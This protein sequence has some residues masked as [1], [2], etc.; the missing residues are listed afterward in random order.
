MDMTQHKLI[1]EGRDHM[2]KN[3][4]DGGSRWTGMACICAVKEGKAPN[5]S[6][7]QACHYGL[8]DFE[9]GT[10]AIVSGLMKPQA[11]YVL[12]EDEALMFLDWLLNRSP[13]S[14]VFITKSPHEALLHKVIVSRTDVPSNLMAAGLVASRR[15]WEYPEVARVFCDLVKAGVDED[16]AFW[17]GHIARCSFNRSGNCDW[18]SS[19][20]GHCSMNS[21]AFGPKAMVNWLSHKPTSLNKNY[22]EA[23]R[24]SGYAE[25]FGEDYGLDQ[26]VHKNFPYQK[27]AVKSLNP[28]PLDGGIDANKTCKYTD[29]IGG[30]V[31]FQ[32]KI[33]DHIGWKKVK[34]AKA[35]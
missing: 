3:L 15:L 9:T 10:L 35:A 8:H 34:E 12:D 1:I 24:Y 4:N 22:N 14:E 20:N 5:I 6:G 11:A 23:V 33:F 30:M 13:Y 27:G 28:F 25:M 29:L 26:W 32:H 7:N 17:L 31:D 19:K 18:N 16:L 21:H 2:L